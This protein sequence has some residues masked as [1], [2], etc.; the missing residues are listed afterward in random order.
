MLTL[1]WGNS[2]IKAYKRSI[3][4]HPNLRLDIEKVL[5]HTNLKVNLQVHGLAAPATI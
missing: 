3:K 5:K 1:I 4:K 2:F